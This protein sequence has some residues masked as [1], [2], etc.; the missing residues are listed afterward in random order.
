MRSSLEPELIPG[1]QY[2]A[3]AREIENPRDDFIGG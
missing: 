1:G 3:L 2:R